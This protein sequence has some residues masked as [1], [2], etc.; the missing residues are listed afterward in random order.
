MHAALVLA[1]FPAAAGDATQSGFE[2]ALAGVKLLNVCR[3][4]EIRLAIENRIASEKLTPRGKPM[5]WCA[6]DGW[7]RAP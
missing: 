2:K 7:E 1:L 5:R 3:S 6:Y 4:S